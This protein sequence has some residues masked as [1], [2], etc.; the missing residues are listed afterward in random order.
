MHRLRSVLCVSASGVANNIDFG[1]GDAWLIVLD[2]K[3][4][5]KGH[6]MDPVLSYVLFDLS[7][8]RWFLRQ[9]LC[10]VCKNNPSNRA[11]FYGLKNLRRY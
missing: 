1:W 5:V 7:S 2:K 9:F 6:D 4:H 11:H 10:F 8:V 3:G